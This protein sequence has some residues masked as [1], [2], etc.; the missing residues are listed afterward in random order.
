MESRSVSNIIN[1]GGTILRSARSAENLELLKEEKA[2]EQCS[3]RYRRF[4]V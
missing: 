3:T 1:L 2:Y 4:C